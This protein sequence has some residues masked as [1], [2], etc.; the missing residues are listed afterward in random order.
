MTHGRG[1]RCGVD[2]GGT[3][4]DVVES[5]PAAGA[6]AAALIGELT[7]T[8]QVFSFPRPG[9]GATRGVLHPRPDLLK[10]LLILGKVPRLELRVDE[11]A[12][13]RH[14]KTAAI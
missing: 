10:D 5:G 8:T 3:F 13:Q 11:C 1:R 4:T 12:V 2:I 6:L 7:G 9:E 14:F